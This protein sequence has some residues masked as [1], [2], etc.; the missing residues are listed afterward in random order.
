MQT[1]W[2]SRTPAP[3]V[4][5]RTLRPLQAAAITSRISFGPRAK[6][7]VL[8]PRGAMAREGMSPELLCSDIDG[9]SLPA[10][11]RVQAHE[12]KR[13]EQQCRCPTSG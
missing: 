1:H 12:R 7:K 11:V 4:T 3:T 10:A 9:F 6:Q 13:L 2:P 5:K 8:P